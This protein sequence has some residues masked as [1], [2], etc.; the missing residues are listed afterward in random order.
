MNK[1]S[2]GLES[3]LSDARGNSNALLW[4]LFWKR[5]YSGPHCVLTSNTSGLF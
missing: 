2:H 5:N 3:H 4:V 1:N